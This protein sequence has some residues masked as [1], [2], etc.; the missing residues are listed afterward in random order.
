MDDFG[1][2]P[3]VIFQRSGSLAILGQSCTRHPVHWSVLPL[4]PS[5]GETDALNKKVKQIRASVL[6][7][8]RIKTSPLQRAGVSLSQPPRKQYI[9]HQPINCEGGLNSLTL[10]YSTSVTVIQWTKKLL[11]NIHNNGN[12]TA[13]KTESLQVCQT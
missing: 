6:T 5:N 8:I 12:I 7:Q 10:P 11:L 3:P 13:H 9:M 2:E 4:R 1:T